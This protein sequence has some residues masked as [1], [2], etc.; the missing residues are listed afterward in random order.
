M[1]GG[2]AFLVG[3]HMCCGVLDARLMA[4]VGPAQ[5]AA[6]LAAPH[7]RPMDFTGRPLTGYVYVD[8]PGLR[9]AAQ[10][11]RWIDRCAGFVDGLPPKTAETRSRRRK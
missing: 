9:T 5:Y 1:F 10:L 6:A 8:P 4:R 11:R 2:L 7:A 3:G